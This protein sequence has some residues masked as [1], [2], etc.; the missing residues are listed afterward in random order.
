MSSSKTGSKV[1]KKA[2][3]KR[4]SPSSSFAASKGK[5]S[6]KAPKKMA[7]KEVS[8]ASSSCS[9]EEDA[10]P[11]AAPAQE[12]MT[13]T[14]RQV[15]SGRVV[16]TRGGLTKNDIVKNKQGKLVSRVRSQMGA[17]RYRNIKAW[18]AAVCE[19]RTALQIKGFCAVGG[20]TPQGQKLLKA[21]RQIYKK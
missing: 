12:K 6:K 5:K 9:S 18:N 13:G 4:S 19:A 2:L 16:K 7:K 21:A 10:S 20:K 8:P 11:K 14:R 1:V 15:A 17:D 3:S